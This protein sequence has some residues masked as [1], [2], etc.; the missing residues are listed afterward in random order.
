MLSIWLHVTLG[1]GQLQVETRYTT[2]A[3]RVIGEIKKILPGLYVK[4]K[5][6]SNILP[7]KR[8][9]FEIV[10]LVIA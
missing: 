10:A 7:L 6:N 4:N 3:P 1:E 5:K 9:K 2:C 8:V